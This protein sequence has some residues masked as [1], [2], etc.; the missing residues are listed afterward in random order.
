VNGASVVAVTAVAVGFLVGCNED[1]GTTPT[2]TPTQDSISINSITPIAGT[3]LQGGQTVTITA[4]L[5]YSLAS[6]A[7]GEIAIV[8]QDQAARNLEAPGDRGRALAISRGMGV[9]TL[10][11]TVIIPISGV[12]TVNAFFPLGPEGATRTEVVAVATY[13][14]S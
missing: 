12:S 1:S 9:A 11:A 3:R 6:T 14:V 7:T 2:P 8:I 13:P 10:S 5:N 4:T